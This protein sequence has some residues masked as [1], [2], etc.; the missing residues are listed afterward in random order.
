M[1]REANGVTFEGKEDSNTKKPYNGAQKNM[2]GLYK[3]RQQ[4]DKRYIC[5][6]PSRSVGKR[7]PSQGK[8]GGSGRHEAKACGRMCSEGL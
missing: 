4:Q 7:E 8:A 3:K 5:G 2:K 6:R 1:G